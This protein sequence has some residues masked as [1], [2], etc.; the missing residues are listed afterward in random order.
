MSFGPTVTVSRQ[1]LGEELVVAVGAADPLA[2]GEELPI[3]SGM[4]SG[5]RPPPPDGLG[6]VVAVEVADGGAVAVAVGGEL[7]DGVAVA[8]PVGVELP[9]GLGQSL[10]AALAT[11]RTTPLAATATAV[12]TAPTI[13]R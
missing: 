12:Q 1:P 13:S 8:V 3:G 9:D 4:G 6:L 5:G 7:P 10:G 2:L 11:V